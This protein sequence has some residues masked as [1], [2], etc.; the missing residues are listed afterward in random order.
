LC[1]MGKAITVRL[2]RF[3]FASLAMALASSG[4]A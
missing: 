2:D 1:Q 3:I 4:Q